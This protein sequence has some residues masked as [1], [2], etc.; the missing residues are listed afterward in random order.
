MKYLFFILVCLFIS[1]E[2][3]AQGDET[4]NNPETPLNTNQL[5]TSESSDENADAETSEQPADEE[6][7]E[8]EEDPLAEEEDPFAEEDDPF[9]DEEDPFSEEEDPFLGE[10]ATGPTSEKSGAS[11]ELKSWQ[12]YLDQKALILVNLMVRSHKT[13]ERNTRLELAE[14]ARQVIEE[15]DE[16]AQVRMEEER[17]SEEAYQDWNDHFQKRIETETAAAMSS[18]DPETFISLFES[19]WFKSGYTPRL[20]L[21]YRLALEQRNES[22]SPSELPPKYSEQVRLYQEILDLHESGNSLLPVKERLEDQLENT[23]SSL[24]DAD[25]ELALTIINELEIPQETPLVIEDEPLEM[26]EPESIDNGTSEDGGLF[27]D[28]TELVEETAEVPFDAKVS[29]THEINNLLGIS[30]IKGLYLIDPEISE[31]NEYKYSITY[32][33]QFRIQMSEK[34]YSFFRLSVTFT[35]SYEANQERFFDSLFTLREIYNNYRSG[36]HQVRYGNQIF[37]LGKVDFDSTIDTLHLNNI[38]RFFSTFD[39]DKQ[40]ESLTSVKYS[41]F[42]GEHNFNAYLAPI[43]QETFGMKFVGFRDSLEQQQEGN[44]EE[45]SSIFRDYFGL[46]YQWTGDMVDA[47]MS[48]FQWFDVDPTTSFVY[49]RSTSGG[50]IKTAFEGL[51]S[52]YSEKES[53]SNFFALE[54]DALWKGM[55]WKLDAGFYN[56]KNFSSYHIENENKLYF[57]TTNVPYTAWATSF[58]RTFPYFYWIMIYSQRKL[59]GVPAGTHVLFYENESSLAD[60]SR[61]L[62]RNQLT[63]IAVVK[64]PDNQLRVA[65]IHYLTTP[66]NQR[67]WLILGTWERPEENYILEFK[68]YSVNAGYQKMLDS[69]LDT[70]QFYLVYTQKFAGF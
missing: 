34:T 23:S 41:W 9:A 52:S 48:Y 11:P 22:F 15:I 26:M 47:R 65:T 19:G 38:M 66:Y 6:R 33:P 68:F 39:P 20:V 18:G 62:Q 40:K 61:D 67:G 32:S 35:Q 28:L 30:E 45:S 55:A 3:F 1:A 64:T 12:N 37:K 60:T 58:E 2:L 5:E 25:L 46:Q 29:F 50:S 24:T 42:G 14:K 13:K 36:E 4:E 16:E 7:F 54:L 57:N 44:N 59:S 17:L 51:M 69:V 49:D 31:I 8:S 56:R 21:L 53:R 43:K 27:N 10:S 70:T 63:G